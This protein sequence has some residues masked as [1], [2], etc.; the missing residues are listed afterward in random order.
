ME[1]VSWKFVEVGG[2]LAQLG[3]DGR[4]AKQPLAQVTKR[5]RRST[6]ADFH[7]SE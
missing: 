4:R 7:S 2:S 1:V 3:R 6:T 5:M